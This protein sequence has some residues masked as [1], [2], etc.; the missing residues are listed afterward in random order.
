M[1]VKKVVL[2][3]IPTGDWDPAV[4]QKLLDDIVDEVNSTMD[5][6]GEHVATLLKY[7][8]NQTKAI[9]MEYASTETLIAAKVHTKMKLK[10]AFVIVADNLKKPVS[11]LLQ[12][13]NHK[14][15]LTERKVVS[16]TDKQGKAYYLKPLANREIAQWDSVEVVIDANRK[17]IVIANFEEAE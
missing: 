7:N 11:V 5:D 10:D 9:L 2:D 6:V 4:L 14:E 16:R 8:T 1:T 17:V 12:K 13:G 3:Y 15:P